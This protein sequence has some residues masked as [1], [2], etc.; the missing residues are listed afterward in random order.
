MHL[1]V[2]VLRIAVLGKNRPLDE[3]EM[4]FL[5][6]VY[7]SESAREQAKQE[8]ERTELA[9]FQLVGILPMPAFFEG[10]LEMVYMK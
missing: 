8:E 1:P 4:Q 7:K 3:D 10:N 2:A 6:S 5:D 9:A